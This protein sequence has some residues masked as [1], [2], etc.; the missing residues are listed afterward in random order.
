V[1]VQERGAGVVAVDRFLDLLV[2][3]HRNIGGVGRNP[4]RA[5]RRDLDDQGLLVFGKE[6]VVEELQGCLR[7][8]SMK[9]GESVAPAAF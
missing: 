6:G 4:F 7:R 5:V 9:C 8:E 2:H 3:R 1:D